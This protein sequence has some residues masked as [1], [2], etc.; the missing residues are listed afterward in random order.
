KS[1][2][3]GATWGPPIQV[4]SAVARSHFDDKGHIAV[5]NKSFTAHRGSVYVAWARLDLNQIRFARSTNGGV[6]F[7]PD[8]QVND[9][10]NADT[11]V[12]I[13]VGINGDVY[14]AWTDFTTNQIRIDKSTNGGQSFGALTGGTD[15]TIR[16]LTPTFS[17][18]PLARVNSFPVI[19]TDAFNQDIVYAVWAEYPA[20]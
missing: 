19:A 5:D 18:R 17:V 10:A 9:M 1:L 12:N 6:S 14:V 2:D 8:I 20:G 4:S 7:E 16:S 15:H 11:G 3:G 13:A